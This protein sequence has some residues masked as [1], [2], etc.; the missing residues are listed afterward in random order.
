M[1]PS[2]SSV[3]DVLES[4]RCYKCSNHFPAEMDSFWIYI[5]TA[6]DCKWY[7]LYIHIYIL[8]IYIYIYVYVHICV[9]MYMSHDCH[10]IP[11]IFYCSKDLR[12][13]PGTILRIVQWP[14]NVHFSLP[15]SQEVPSDK[16]T[17]NYGIWKITISFGGKSLKKNCHFFNSKLL[18]SH[19][20]I[21]AVQTVNCLTVNRGV[22]QFTQLSFW[23]NP[24][25]SP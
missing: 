22:S 1:C 20:S 13:I 18:K 8:Y 23:Q 14:S 16:H 19:M 2:R 9:S 24:H 17:K 5:Y 25:E 10:E 6:N 3:F 15:N 11:G 21:L 12:I 4:G 7:I